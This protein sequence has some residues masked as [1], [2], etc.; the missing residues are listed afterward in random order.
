MAYSDYFPGIL[1]EG[2]TKQ[3]RNLSQDRR[4]PGR[5]SNQPPPEYKTQAFPLETAYVLIEMIAIRY[6][7]MC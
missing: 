3:L 4:F 7:I 1:L 2:L 5:E 6:G